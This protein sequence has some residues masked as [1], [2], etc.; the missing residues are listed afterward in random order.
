MELPVAFL[1]RFGYEPW[2]DDS[3]QHSFRLTLFFFYSPYFTY[4]ATDRASLRSTT[5]FLI[6]T[7]G[8]GCSTQLLPKVYKQLLSQELSLPIDFLHHQLP[9][10]AVPD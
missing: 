5:L 2:Y 6:T 1:L 9:P 3:A 10:F 7:L 8:S 4:G